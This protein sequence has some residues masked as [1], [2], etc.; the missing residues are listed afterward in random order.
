MSACTGKT[1]DG[2]TDAVGC[3][4]D[5]PGL[6]PG[7]WKSDRPYRTSSTA[8]MA[9]ITVEVL[10]LLHAEM[11]RPRRRPAI[12]MLTKCECTFPVYVLR[13]AAP[14]V[15]RGPRG[16]SGVLTGCIV[17][18]L[19]REWFVLVIFICATCEHERPSRRRGGLGTQGRAPGEG[20]KFTG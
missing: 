5:A 17:C 13:V 4:H 3:T 8:I 15:A 9:L 16:F 1:K 2:P 19:W 10:P 20:V 11:A 6:G 14:R 18:A 7:A 12:C